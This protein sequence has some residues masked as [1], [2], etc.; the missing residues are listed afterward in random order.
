MDVAK[1][2]EILQIDKLEKR[3]YRR[4]ADVELRLLVME[5]KEPADSPRPCLVFIHG[6]GF[7]GGKPEMLLP[8]CRYFTRLGYVCVS[9]EYR[10]IQM[11]GE[12]PTGDSI[13][14]EDCIVDCKEAVRYVRSHAH[15]WNVDANR[16]GLIGESAGGYLACAVTTLIHIEDTTTSPSV[17]CVPNVLVAYNPITHLL[18][19]WKA[20]LHYNFIGEDSAEGWLMKHQQARNLSPLV[21]LSAEHPPTLNIHGLMDSVVPPEH[22]AEYAERLRELGVTVRLE[23]LPASKH[24]FALFNYTATEDE[25]ART[26]NITREFLS[27]IL[28]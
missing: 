26:L 12:F 8:Q 21:Y 2:W 24:A 25:I 28:L 14:L 6:G 23:L 19:G 16:I 22:S 27:S 11:E 1:E 20:R 7:T 9:V 18:C 13:K 3:I 17:S 15:Q 5:P 10:L 4:I